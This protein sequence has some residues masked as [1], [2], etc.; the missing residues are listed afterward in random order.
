[1]DGIQVLKRIVARPM[2]PPTIMLT[3]HSEVRL[4]TSAIQTGAW[5]YV[6]KPY[7]LAQ[8]VGTIR[9]AIRSAESRRCADSME[10]S[11]LDTL[12][13]ESGPMRVLKELILRYSPSDSPLLL[14]GESGT[15]KELVARSAHLVSHRR[16]LPFVALNCAGLAESILE[17]ELFGSEKGAFTDAVCRPGSFEQASGGTLFLDEIAEM[18]VKAQ[19][20]LLR[21]LE[22][23]ELTRIGG[24][25]TTPIDVRVASA[26]NK[27]LKA[28]VKCGEFREDLYYRLSVLPIHVPA[29]RERKD[30]IPLLAVHFLKLFSRRQME[31]A[32]DA[33]EKLSCHPWPGNI[34][35]LR[36]VMERATLSS[37]GDLVRAG[38]ILFD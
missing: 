6:Q 36:S 14:Q 7:D 37:D 19:G 13:G 15:G 29:L 35:E 24:T 27:D 21:I 26:T 28:K 11:V 5:D 17:T 16:S 8:L 31:I 1:M 30:D 32:P 25:R 3:A 12:V 4:V 2:A 23:K 38:D 9:T 20:R 34:R 18:S 33:R 22:Q 10:P